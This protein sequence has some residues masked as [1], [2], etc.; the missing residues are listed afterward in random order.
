MGVVHANGVLC[1]P[2]VD[3]FGRVGHEHFAGEV[4]LREDI[5]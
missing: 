4:C 2:F 5:R 3:G 1:G